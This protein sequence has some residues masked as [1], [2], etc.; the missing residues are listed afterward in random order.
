MTPR[1]ALARARKGFYSRAN[2]YFFSLAGRNSL[3]ERVVSHPEIRTF[4]GNS[5]KNETDGA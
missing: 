1:K 2:L 4:R 5:G 3:S